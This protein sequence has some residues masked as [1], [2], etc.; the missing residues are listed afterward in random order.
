[1][2]IFIIIFDTLRKDHTGKIY[3]ND[4]IQTPNFDAIAKDSMVFIKAYPESLPTIPARRAIHTGIRTFPFN[5]EKPNLKTDDIVEIPGWY[6]IPPQHTHLVE[7]L[8][9]FGYKSA[10]ITSTYHQFKPNMNFHLGYDQWNWIRGHEADAL[11]AHHGTSKAKFSRKI[12]K[13]VYGDRPEIKF[14]QRHFLEGYFKNVLDRKEENQYFPA[15][16]LSKAM[17][18]A[19]D[20]KKLNNTFCIIDE[21]DPHEPWDPPKKYL[22]LYV[23]K[24]YDGPKAINPIYSNDLSFI[25]EDE[26]KYMRACYAGEVTMCDA[27]FGKF[28][29][30][31]KELE[32]YEESLI[33]LTS[34]HGHN[35]GEHGNMGKLPY[36]LYPQL[37][38]IPMIIKPPYAFKGPK[39]ITKSYVYHHDLASTVLGFINKDKPEALEGIDL[40]IFSEEEDHLIEKRDYIT[41]GFGLYTL[42]KDDKHALITHNDKSSRRLFDLSTDP[43]WNENIADNNEDLYKDLFHKIENDA[44]GELLLTFESSLQEWYIQKLG[45]GED[46]E[47]KE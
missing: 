18:F 3:G 26:L 30:K 39:L 19:S 32:I 13:Y 40:S 11:R 12:R 41:C 33:I 27:W 34:D 38:D 29:Q 31:L 45:F 21:F 28:I 36:C 23:D 37:V 16:T 2:K 5:H 20:T 47:K 43:D 10:F 17:E 7:Y 9:P 1:M 42:Y 4:W 35:I 44:K 14:F 6:P 15:Q 8:R 46:N 24:S 25:K 22:D